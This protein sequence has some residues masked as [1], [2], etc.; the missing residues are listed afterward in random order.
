MCLCL[1]VCV[2]VCAC[3]LE[4]GGCWLLAACQ[5]SVHIKYILHT[6]KYFLAMNKKSLH[7]V[8]IQNFGPRHSSPTAKVAAPKDRKAASP[9]SPD[10]VYHTDCESLS[11]SPITPLVAVCRL[12]VA[13]WHLEFGS[14]SPAT[15]LAH[16]QCV[17]I[18]VLLNLSWML[19][20]GAHIL[21]IFAL[22]HLSTTCG[23]A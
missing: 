1:C 14:K 23:R 15:M 6:Q 18:P 9:W 2:S 11:A 12:H 5:E 7:S 22:S 16:A 3:S 17:A 20:D 19:S 13:G 4:T 10:Y 8:S 21:S